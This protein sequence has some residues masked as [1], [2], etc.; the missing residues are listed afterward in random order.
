MWVRRILSVVILLA[1]LA[2]AGFL[3]VKL[4]G[5]VK[6]KLTDQ[7][8]QIA[9]ET[10]TAPVVVGPCPLEDLDVE[11]TP[12]PEEVPTGQGVRLNLQVTSSFREQCSF[13]SEE[14]AV[15]LQVG[16]YPVWTPTACSEEWGRV[17]LLSPA[18]P[19]QTSLTWDGKVYEACEVVMTGEEPAEAIAGAGLYH[20]HVSLAG[21]LVG[22]P[23]ADVDEGE[24]DGSVAGEGDADSEEEYDEDVWSEVEPY[25][26]VPILVY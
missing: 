21:Q 17:L 20:A 6:E 13:D 5:F 15:E 14:I 11:V 4:F 26:G 16:G 3:G 25:L 23:R 18:T 22:D 1:L 8:K 10:G 7:Q 12:D 24:A 9:A 19:W 2:G